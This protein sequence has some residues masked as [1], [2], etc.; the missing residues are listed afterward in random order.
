M[1][2]QVSEAIVLR[3]YPFKESDLIVSLF[4]RDQGKLRGVANRARRHKTGFGSTL[5]RLTRIQV[6]YSMRENRELIRID[7]CDLIESN[8][9]LSASFPCGLALDLFTEISESLLPPHEANEKYFRLLIAVLDFLRRE[10]ENGIWQAVT[11][12]EVWSVRLS[13]FLPDLRLSPDSSEILDQILK[14]PLRQLPP[15]SWQQSTAADL[16]RSLTK[17]IETHTERRLTTSPMLETL[18]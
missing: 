14:T 4:T 11:Y 17:L 12:F 7:H 2:A 1:P 13:G 9:D 16:R 6:H 5:E 10:G 15:R 18:I 8:F 3:T